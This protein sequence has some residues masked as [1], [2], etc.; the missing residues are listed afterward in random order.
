VLAPWLIALIVVLLIVEFVADKVPAVDHA[1]D[2]VQTVVRPAVGGLLALSASGQASV[3]PVLLVA[4]GVLI[5]GSVHVVKA[6]ARPAVN[7]STA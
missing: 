5:A 2:V 6:S 3:P 7:V 4:A 1:N